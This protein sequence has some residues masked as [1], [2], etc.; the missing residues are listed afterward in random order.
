MFRNKKRK[1]IRDRLWSSKPNTLRKNISRRMLSRNSTNWNIIRNRTNEKLGTDESDSKRQT[2]KHRDDI[3]V[4][5]NFGITSNDNNIMPI[6]EDDSQTISL[7]PLEMDNVTTNTNEIVKHN[8]ESS[9]YMANPLLKSND[10]ISINDDNISFNGA[11]HRRL[12]SSRVSYGMKQSQKIQSTLKRDDRKNKRV[13]LKVNKY[14][15]PKDR[16]M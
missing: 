6:L 11:L 7:K 4:T 12:V 3:A 5:S 16:L 13:V 14:I 9:R 8:L 2:F 15:E 1:I 10:N